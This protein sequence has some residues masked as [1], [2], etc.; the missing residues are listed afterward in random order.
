MKICVCIKEVPDSDV[1]SNKLKIDHE[2][3]RILPSEKVPSIVNGFDLNAV[4]LA[5]RFSEITLVEEKSITTSKLLKNRSLLSV[6]LVPKDPIPAI[7]PQSFPKKG[8]L[9]ASN[10]PLSLKSLSE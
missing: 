7:T 1:P 9:L 6:I 3:L 2:N 5:L 4:E 10:A 8:L